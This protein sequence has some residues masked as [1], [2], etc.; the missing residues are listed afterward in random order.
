M[1]GTVPHTGLRTPSHPPKPRSA[2]PQPRV[3]LARCRQ[4]PGAS[5]SRPAP[6]SG[7]PA[8]TLRHVIPRGTLLPK[9][10]LGRS[11]ETGGKPGRA[12]R[13]GAG[14]PSRPRSC[15][16]APSLPLFTHPG[17]GQEG[18]ARS[19]LPH[20]VAMAMRA[21]GV[22]GQRVTGVLRGDTQGRER[23]GAKRSVV[24]RSRANQRTG[25]A[26][27]FYHLRTTPGRFLLVSPTV[28][29]EPGQASKA[30]ARPLSSGSRRGGLGDGVCPPRL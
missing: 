6:R 24:S 17:G 7:S 15:H 9:L 21:G 3:A 29:Q 27:E 14:G 4:Q 23:P 13:T 26:Q 8:Q 18:G 11:Q 10:R 1:R 12:Q 2:P 25:A 20:G 5:E 28:Y 16:P 19:H 22:H 30:R